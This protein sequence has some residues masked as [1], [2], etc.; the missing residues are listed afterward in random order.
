MGA[1]GWMAV[2]SWWRGCLPIGCPWVR[3]EEARMKSTLDPVAGARV[4]SVGGSGR[5]PDP[6]WPRWSEQGFGDGMIRH[7][8]SVR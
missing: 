2:L 1:V 4:D 3:G 8:Y 7:R 5:L 6:V